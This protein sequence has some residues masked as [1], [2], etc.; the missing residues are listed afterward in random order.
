MRL[1][2]P[3]LALGLLAACAPQ[4]PDSGRGVGFDD[5]ASLR[6]ERD[7]AL[8]TGTPL[9]PPAAISSEPLDATAQGGAP[10]ELPPGGSIL[11]PP[12]GT[13]PGDEDAAIAAEAAAA[14]AA[15]NSGEVPLQASPSNPAPAAVNSFGISNENDFSAVSERRSIES[16]AERIARIRQVRTEVAPTA[17]PPRP[18]DASPNIVNYALSTSHPKGTRV[19]SRSGI[20]L[21]ARAQRNCA[22]YASPDQAQ[23]AF[24]ERGGPD[25]DRLGLDPDG[26]GY[27]CA[28]DPAPFRR[29]VR[30]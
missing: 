2:Y 26:D 30:H 20:N 7:A 25:R 3:I 21:V 5:P 19:H 17:L 8:T 10:G 15:A 14:L 24:L 9:A 4:V 22:K 16:D 11:E 28:W 13:S 18:E 27:A 23:I 29:A 1:T 6:A 12:P